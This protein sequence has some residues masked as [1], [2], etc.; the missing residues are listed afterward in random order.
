[1]RKIQYKL[2]ALSMACVLIA[3]GVTGCGNEEENNTDVTSE[4]PKKAETPP[5]KPKGA[6]PEKPEGEDVASEEETN[7]TSA[8]TLDTDT[9][10]NGQT[11]L[12]SEQDENALRVEKGATVTISDFMVQKTDG[13]TS[14]TGNSD[15]YGLN[16]GVLVRDG[17]KATLQNLKIESSAAGANAV[18]AY[19]EKTSVK[20]LNGTIDTK[21]D[22]SGGVDVAGGALIDAE[23]LNVKTYGKSSA[24]IRSDRGGGIIKVKNGSYETYGTG[25]PAIYSTAA[26][27]AENT[28]MTA[29]HSEA[30]VVEGANSVTITN[31]NISGSMDGTYGGDSAENIHNVM[32]YQSMSGDAMQGQSSFSMKYGVLSAMQGDMFYITNTSAKIRLENVNFNCAQDAYLV[33]VAGN[34]GSRGWGEAGQ[35]GGTLEMETFNENMQGNIAVDDISSLTLKLNSNSRLVGTINSENSKGEITVILS[36]DSYWDLTGDSYITKFEGDRSKIQANGHHVFVNGK[37]II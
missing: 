3:G 17:S 30:V 18:F 29:A 9:T 27:Y 1:M 19:G 21:R 6:P 4:L 28:N 26:I 20:L 11:Y 15:F 35:N 23:N 24:A 25:S 16:A 14:N 31:C 33:N 34:D 32:L 7:G 10:E 5:E 13:D 22:H 36:S 2:V 8:Y 37:K 12:S